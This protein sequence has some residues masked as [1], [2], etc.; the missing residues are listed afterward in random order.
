MRTRR[1]QFAGRYLRQPPASPGSP[2]II[3]SSAHGD[4]RMPTTLIDIPNRRF[5]YLVAPYPRR[6]V[7]HSEATTVSEPGSRCAHAPRV[8]AGFT[9]AAGRSAP[10]PAIDPCPARR[11]DQDAAGAVQPSGNRESIG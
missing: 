1:V 6:V 10:G 9:D 3:G 11:S 4:P 2:F 7:T 8:G 5:A